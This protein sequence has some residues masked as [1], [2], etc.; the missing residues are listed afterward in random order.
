MNEQIKYVTE[1]E[2][3][4]SRKIDGFTFGEIKVPMKALS[5]LIDTSAIEGL[6]KE[7]VEDKEPTEQDILDTQRQ[8]AETANDPDMVIEESH[9]FTFPE[10]DKSKKESEKNEIENV[11]LESYT[12]DS[13][14]GAIRL[15]PLIIFVNVTNEDGERDSIGIPG[16]FDAEN[17]R[18]MSLDGSPVRAKDFDSKFK[19][20]IYQK[21]TEISAQDA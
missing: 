8:L 17:D 3:A 10:T 19:K 9:T 14:L 20:F 21:K 13:V 16:F 12:V 18:Y 4:A 15:E 5:V 7:K 6:S 1:D 11:Q 2:I